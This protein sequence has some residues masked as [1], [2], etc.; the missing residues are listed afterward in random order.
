MAGVG[1]DSIVQVLGSLGKG[2]LL[3]AQRG[4]CKCKTNTHL[5]L[6][7]PYVETEWEGKALLDTS[8]S[9]RTISGKPPIHAT[10]IF[11][12]RLLLLDCCLEPCGLCNEVQWPDELLVEN[13]K[14]LRNNLNRRKIDV[15]RAQPKQFHT[16]ATQKLWLQSSIAGRVLGTRV[17]KWRVIGNTSV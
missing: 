2:S 6:C 15:G 11:F 7:T 9:P 13:S 1:R 3:A 5:L 17:L 16:F 12:P 8:F 10:R 14:A 4:I